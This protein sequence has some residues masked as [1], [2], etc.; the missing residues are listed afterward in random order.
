VQNTIPQTSLPPP[1]T[2]RETLRI[3]LIDHLMRIKHVDIEYARYALAQYAD[4]LP[5]MDLGAGVREAI[6]A[7]Q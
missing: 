4:L 7:K 5:W 3:R 2:P 1:C 6:K